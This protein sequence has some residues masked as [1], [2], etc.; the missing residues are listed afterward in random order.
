MT[1]ILLTL[2]SIVSFSLVRSSMA[3]SQFCIR[4]SDASF[5]H[6]E[7]KAFLSVAGTYFQQQQSH[8]LSIFLIIIYFKK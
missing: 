5:P 7:L 1:N 8:T 6:R 3:A 2:L 4:I